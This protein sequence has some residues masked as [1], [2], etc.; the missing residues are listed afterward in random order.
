M[1]NLACPLPLNDISGKSP[2]EKML[3]AMIL[4]AII[5]Y[6]KAVAYYGMEFY[7]LP[8]EKMPFKG[9]YSGCRHGA[10][11]DARK[12]YRRKI[13]VNGR[14]AHAYIFSPVTPDE[15]GFQGVCDSLSM[16]ANLFRNRLKAMQQ[17]EAK[18]LVTRVLSER[19]KAARAAA[20]AK[21][22]ANEKVKR[23]V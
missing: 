10:P 7:K 16:N 18:V 21:E 22:E 5:D 15:E 12:I 17:G 2:E 11:P 20:K 19:K 1:A 6:I 14:Q 13:L 3:A 8:T 9:C 23:R 4:N